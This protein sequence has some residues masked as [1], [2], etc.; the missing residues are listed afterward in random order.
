MLS[1]GP[2][3]RIDMANW[4]VKGYLNR[5][6]LPTAANTE[7]EARGLAAY[8]I[9]EGYDHVEIYRRSGESVAFKLVDELHKD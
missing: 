4:L 9:K 6:M 2:L 8:M 3:E 1:I 7:S 5:N